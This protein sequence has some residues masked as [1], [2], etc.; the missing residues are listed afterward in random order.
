LYLSFCSE[1][2]PEGPEYEEEDED[3]DEDFP[4]P[5]RI[6]PRKIIEKIA[7]FFMNNLLSVLKIY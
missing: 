2:S 6:A 3:E 4:H 5:T 1:L 7:V